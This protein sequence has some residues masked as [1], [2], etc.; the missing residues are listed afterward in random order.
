MV[1]TVMRSVGVF[2]YTCTAFISQCGCYCQDSHGLYF[3]LVEVEGLMLGY[4]GYNMARVVLPSG[5]TAK[6]SD[7]P[8]FRYVEKKKKKLI[9]ANFKLYIYNVYTKEIMCQKFSF[10]KNIK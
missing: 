10:R 8:P 5:L 2:K 7:L 1:D 4:D 6:H 3:L 9:L